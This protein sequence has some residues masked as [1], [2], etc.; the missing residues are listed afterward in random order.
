MSKGSSCCF[1]RIRWL[2]ATC[3]CLW[4]HLLIIAIY[5]CEQPCVC[6]WTIFWF[7]WDRFY[8]LG[9]RVDLELISFR[10]L[11]WIVFPCFFYNCFNRSSHIVDS[12]AFVF[13]YFTNITT[14]TF[15]WR[16]TDRDSSCW[17]SFIWRFICKTKLKN[18][19]LMLNTLP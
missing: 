12:I 7:L 11:N 16:T 10:S 15:A 1:L 2:F 13:N 17:T 3:F 18:K 14:F 5:R 9:I 8:C 4:L 19:L 6:C